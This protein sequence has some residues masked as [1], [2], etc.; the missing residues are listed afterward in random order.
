ME[1]PNPVYQGGKLSTGEPLDRKREYWTENF[2]EML[3]Q[4]HIIPKNVKV[5]LKPHTPRHQFCLPRGVIRLIE[6]ESEVYQLLSFPRGVPG[7]EDNCI[8]AHHAVG[9]P[10]SLSVN[11]NSAKLN[12]TS[13]TKQIMTGS[14]ANLE[15][16]VCKESGPFDPQASFR[17]QSI[18]LNQY[19]SQYATF[20]KYQRT[21]TL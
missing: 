10:L 15:R 2:I 1:L 7:E 16:G 3:R 9:R 8:Q 21:D 14:Q 17:P 11:Y 4:E 12:F 19:E 13:L 6:Q 5:D 20:N 18:S